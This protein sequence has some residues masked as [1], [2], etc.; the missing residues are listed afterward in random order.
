MTVTVHKGLPPA[1]RRDGARLYWQAFGTKLGRVLGPEP[2]AMAFLMRV[3]EAEQCVMAMA[4]DGRL[5]GLAGFK[6]DGH[7]F[8]GGTFDDLRA[9]YG[10]FGAFW[11]GGLLSALDREEVTDC[12]L[13]DGIC[14][15]AKARGQGVGAALLAALYDEAAKLG[16]RSIRLDVVDSNTR[17]RAL[18]DREGFLPTRTT[19]LGLL[20]HVFGFA[21]ST[22]MIRPLAA[23]SPLAGAALNTARLPSP[24]QPVRI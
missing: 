8:A 21:S 12:F 7:S 3:I 5:I 2:R 22:T 23:P 10:R 14:V 20:R 4:P 13:M 16:Y 18:Y 1:F 11:R 24:P 9:V 19:R 17:A 15:D 6:T